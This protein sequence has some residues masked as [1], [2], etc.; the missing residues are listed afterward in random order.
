[1]PGLPGTALAHAGAGADVGTAAAQGQATASQAC[2]HCGHHH[3]PSTFTGCQRL[4]SRV[5]MWNPCCQCMF[6]ALGDD[7]LS[8]LL[9]FLGLV[10]RT[11]HSGVCTRWFYLLNSKSMWTSVSG[12]SAR[13]GHVGLCPFVRIW[14]KRRCPHL[15]RTC[16]PRAV[17][18]VSSSCTHPRHIGTGQRAC[19]RRGAAKAAPRGATPGRQ[20]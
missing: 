3:H 17:G 15:F 1:M 6:S 9:S 2:T 12:G 8:H 11:R 13:P 10:D 14:E 4:G 19:A 18:P 16:P 7:L 20:G 5:G